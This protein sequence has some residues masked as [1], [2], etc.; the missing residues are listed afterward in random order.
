MRSPTLHRLTTTFNRSHLNSIQLSL[1]S[2]STFNITMA[3]S[4]SNNKIKSDDG[5][6]AVKDATEPKKPPEIPPPP[7]KPLPGDCCGSGCVRCVWD[8]YYDEL[9]EYNKICKG[10]SDSTAGSKGF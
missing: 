7:E 2:D 6:S 8:V 1:R 3:D 9:E 4:G 5:S 10:G